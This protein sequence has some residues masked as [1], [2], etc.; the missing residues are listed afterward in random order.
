MVPYKH[1][2][3]TI[4]FML[5]NKRGY[6]FLSPGCGKTSSALWFLE[7]LFNAGKIKRAL[8]IAPL[9]TLS[10]VWLDEVEK[11]TPSLSAVVMHGTREV[12]I[13]A[14]NSRANIVITNTDCPRFYE[15][16]LIDAKFDVIIVDEITY[17]ANHTSKRSKALQKICKLARACYGLTGTPVAGNLLDS[18][19]L[20]KMI[21]PSMLPTP[22]ITKYRSLIQEQINMYV[23]VNRPD[24]VERV[25][26][27][28]QPAIKYTLDECVDIPE[29]VYQERMVPLVQK[30]KNLFDKMVKD[31]VAQIEDGTITTATAAVA[32]IRLIQIAT[33]F[34]KD[35]D[36]VVHRVDI[37]NKLSALLEIFHEAGG[38]LVVFCQAVATVK[39]IKEYFDQSNV[40]CHMIY[41]DISLKKRSL[42]IEAFQH[43]SNSVIVCQHATMSHG[44][45]LT[46]SHTA[47]FFGP[48]LGNGSYRQAIHRVRRIGQTHKQLVIQLIS[49]PFER[50]IFA[51]MDDTDMDANALLDLY[52][53]L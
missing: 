31:Q 51:K 32:V 5:R 39:M 25:N 38:K 28:L 53:N 8:V 19:G 41:G 4:D 22:Y 29:I 30:S 21:N 27:V 13:D 44:I 3:A 37:D 52:K 15:Q 20:A 42:M 34:A 14:L 33:G 36:G 6:L 40:T 12:R 17:F 50:K 7:K 18:F 23:Y 10:S 9:S 2:I 16:E 35:D 49:T 24:S 45:T 46:A 48:I 11:A 43:E 26:K 1:Q 47:V